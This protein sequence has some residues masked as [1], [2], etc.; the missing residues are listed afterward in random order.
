M[1]DRGREKRDKQ[2]KTI[3]RQTISRIDW[4]TVRDV[5]ILKDIIRVE[6]DK[7]ATKT[8][9][10]CDVIL[11]SPCP[12]PLA[13][14]EQQRRIS[15]GRLLPQQWIWPPPRSAPRNPETHLLAETWNKVMK[16]FTKINITTGNIA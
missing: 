15:P 12:V 3:N 1:G 6:Y 16:A 2:S 10:P 7:S 14:S 5:W 4:K 9:T 11:Y 13:P 8:T